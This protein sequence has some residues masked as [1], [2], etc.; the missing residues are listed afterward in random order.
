MDGQIKYHNDGNRGIAGQF[1]SVY[2][3]HFLR[4]R[5]HKEGVKTQNNIYNTFHFTTPA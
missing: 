2:L 5:H 1:V 4:E 3:L